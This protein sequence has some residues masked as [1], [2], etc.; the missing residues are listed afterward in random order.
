MKILS[1]TILS[2]I[3]TALLGSGLL[4]PQ[5]HAVPI[6]GTVGF[7]GSG[8]ATQAGGQT[9][10]FFNNPMTVTFGSGNYTGTFGQSATF[11]NF[12]FTGTGNGAALI[13]SVTPLWTFS[14]GPIVFSFDLTSL[15][16]G[17]LTP[18]SGGSPDAIAVSGQGTARET[19]FDPT[20]ATFALNGTG[21]GFTF[22]IIQ[23][24]TT[25]TGQGV[26]DGGST[27][28]LLG[29]ALLGVAGVR[30]MLASKVA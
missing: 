27:V 4:A 13:G 23:S 8:T 6:N 18:G 16:S 2:V 1:T 21:T 26:P 20:F 30:R 15:T 29:I 19:G 14:L 9:N 3:A 25:A 5:A 12:S 11:Q 22:T 10:I 24:S 28:A 7:Q 17:T